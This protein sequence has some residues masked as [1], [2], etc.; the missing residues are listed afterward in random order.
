TKGAKLLRGARGRLPADV[1]ALAETLAKLSYFAV[2]YGDAIASVD[3]NPFLVLPEGQGA[4]ALDCLI[5][6]RG[7]TTD[8]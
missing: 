3:I 5:V 1:G 4:L 8:E 2:Q 6:P 7:A